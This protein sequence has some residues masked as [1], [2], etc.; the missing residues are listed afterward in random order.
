MSASIEGCPIWRWISFSRL[1]D[2]FRHGSIELQLTET[3]RAASCAFSR[4]CPESRAVVIK[5]WTFSLYLHWIDLSRHRN[6][7]SMPCT[8]MSREQPLL[9][10]NFTNESF[11]VIPAKFANFN[12][13]N[14][15]RNFVLCSFKFLG[16][17]WLNCPKLKSQKMQF[18]KF[19][20]QDADWVNSVS[21]PE[22]TKSNW[23]QFAPESKKSLCKVRAIPKILI[24]IEFASRYVPMNTTMCF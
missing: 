7:L 14:F 24:L 18:L 10:G 3:S 6:F 4:K 11:C 9:H 8:T 13:Q 19:F 15:L 12:N 2:Y 16:W 5:C 20:Q 23:W 21:P 17:S 22:T 1:R